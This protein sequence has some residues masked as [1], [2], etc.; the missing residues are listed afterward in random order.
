MYLFEFATKVNFEGLLIN[1][2]TIKIAFD[3][4]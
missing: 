3:G 2:K 1:K 4:F